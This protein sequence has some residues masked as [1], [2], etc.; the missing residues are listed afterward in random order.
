MT[1][2][3][4]KTYKSLLSHDKIDTY[5]GVFLICGESFLVKQAHEYLIN[6]LSAKTSSCFAVEKTDGETTSLGDIIEQVF[7]FSFL[8]PQKIVLVSNMPLFATD[9]PSGLIRYSASDLDYLSDMLKKG[10]PDNHYLVIT[11]PN[12]DKR[13]K[14]YKAINEIGLI[15]DC[16][17]AQ[18][19]RKVDVEEQRLVLRTLADTVLKKNNKQIDPIAFQTL[20]EMTGFNLDLFL[21]NL[22]KLISFIGTNSAITLKDVQS[23]VVRDKKDPIF[24]FTNA[25]MDKNAGKALTVLNSLF[26]EGYHPLQIIKSLENLLRKLLLSANYLLLHHGDKRSYLK[27]MNFN[28][29]KQTIL[30]GMVSYDEKTK[31]ILESQTDILSKDAKK[32]I[33]KSNDLFLAPNPKNAYPIFQVFLKAQN[34]S[35]DQ[36]S[37]GLIFL[38]D[39]DEALKSSSLD[40]KTSIE[41]FIINLCQ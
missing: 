32:K 29:F 13:K 40:E 10:L 20:V 35:P 9:R 4:Y 8:E 41:A 3:K 15:I 28:Q 16:S 1:H 33:S 17:V 2:V 39:L 12:C 23:I 36:L 27:Q 5:N 21:Q 14:I 38:S 22:E 37:K 34:F 6:S 31:Q 7:T 24:N 11:T 25:I 26:T 19:A 30:P 18:G